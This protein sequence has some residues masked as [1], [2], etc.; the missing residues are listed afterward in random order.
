MMVII[1]I[2]KIENRIRVRYCS[3]M[4]SMSVCCWRQ[5]LHLRADVGEVQRGNAH[6]N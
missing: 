1:I 6:Y 2:V 3:V 5:K 4:T